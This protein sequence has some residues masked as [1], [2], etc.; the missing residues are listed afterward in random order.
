MIEKLLEINFEDI[1]QGYTFNSA[2]DKYICNICGCEFEKGEIFKAENRYFEAERMIKVHMHKEHSDLLQ[3]L[4]AYDKKF[5]GITENQKELLSLIS[6]GMTDGEIAK[7]MGVAP[8][9]IRHQR[10]TFREK[11][12]QA[13]LYLAIYELASQSSG[14]AKEAI[15]S[16]EIILDIHKGATMVDDRYLTT[17]GE[18]EQILETAFSSLSPLKL[19]NFSPKEKKKIVILRRIAEQFEKN[20]QYSEKELNSILKEIFEDFATI[21]RYLIEYGFMERTKDCKYYW[22]KI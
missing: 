8:A 17:K 11:A 14:K 5:T 2:S 12:K 13:K 16:K 7:K 18:E 15:D 19:R 4:M 1:K 9:T 6:T 22:I 20:K 21:R 3:F 10:F